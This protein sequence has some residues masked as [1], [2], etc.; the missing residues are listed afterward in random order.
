M[1]R[2]IAARRTTSAD[3]S[4]ATETE[5]HSSAS[6]AGGAPVVDASR[7][8]RDVLPLVSCKRGLDVARDR[9]LFYTYLPYTYLPN[10]LETE[11]EGIMYVNACTARS[12]TRPYAPDASL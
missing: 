11:D 7:H 8:D 3:G 6:Q 12:R 10:T 4:T 9:R 2:W 1:N 5:T